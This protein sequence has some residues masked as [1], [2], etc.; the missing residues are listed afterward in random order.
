MLQQNKGL[1][2]Q[3]AMPINLVNITDH[4]CQMLHS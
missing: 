4:G 1:L 2:L 3:A